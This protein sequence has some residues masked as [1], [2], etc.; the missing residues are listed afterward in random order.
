M[1]VKNRE[2]AKKKIRTFKKGFEKNV[3][4]CV[5]FFHAKVRNITDIPLN[6]LTLVLSEPFNLYNLM[7]LF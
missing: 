2:Q 1:K 4:D 3:R 5:F 6:I 7:I